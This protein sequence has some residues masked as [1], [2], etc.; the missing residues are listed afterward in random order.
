MTRKHIG[1]LL[2]ALMALSCSSCDATPDE[3][4]ISAGPKQQSPEQA[5]R[6]KQ[7]AAAHA[8]A[9]IERNWRT[10]R[11][12]EISRQRQ[13][14][15]HNATPNALNAISRADF[16]GIKIGQPIATALASLQA[17]GYVSESNFYFWPSWRGETRHLDGLTY[18]VKIALIDTMDFK[19]VEKNFTYRLTLGFTPA[20]SDQRDIIRADSK[21]YWIRGHVT[22]YTESTTSQYTEDLAT[23]KYGT[24]YKTP[25]GYRV[26]A[27]CR[28]DDWQLPDIE[29]M[30]HGGPCR[31]TVDVRLG[32]IDVEIVDDI[33]FETER[34]RLVF[35]KIAEMKRTP[36]KIVRPEF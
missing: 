2:A 32:G 10:A 23:A 17:Q 16:T 26:Y 11:L 22:V 21:V 25:N 36:P 13:L 19:K 1:A 29:P 7:W 18:A 27:E 14:D 6:A 34:R 24:N 4:P 5:A 30:T 8:Q 35:E 12:A 9:E 15:F 20:R 28:N 33:L 31:F 3:K